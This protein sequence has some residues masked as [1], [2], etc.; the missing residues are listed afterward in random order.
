MVKIQVKDEKLVDFS[1]MPSLKCNLLCPFCMY[2][3]SPDSKIILDIKKTIN[4]ISTIDFNKINAVGFYGGE[5]ST[6]Y[7]GY[8]KFIDLVPQ[9]IVKFTITN[10]T[11]SINERETKKFIDFALKNKLQ[12]FVSATKFHKLFQNEK[13]L[14]KVAKKYKFVLKSEDRIIPMGRAKKKNW[15]CSKKC[16]NYACP[17]RLTLNPY[18]EIMFCN[19]DGVYPVVGSY[20]DNFKTVVQNGLNIKDF[21]KKLQ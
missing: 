16:L 10:G 8:Q 15:T 4:F 13:L 3:A 17:M 2:K 9:N 11:W 1:F 18:G 5:I 21:C 19:C 20:N 14:K 7:E 6:D 12:V